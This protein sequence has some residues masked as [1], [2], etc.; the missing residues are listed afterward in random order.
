MENP[1][2]D[3]PTKALGVMTLLWIFMALFSLRSGLVF[4]ILFWY[5]LFGVLPWT[6]LVI[7]AFSKYMQRDKEE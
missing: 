3:L 1:R 2:F 5:T 4:V 7:R 6:F